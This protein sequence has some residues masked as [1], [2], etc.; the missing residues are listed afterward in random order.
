[1]HAVH[2]V[3]AGPGGAAVLDDAQLR[4]RSPHVER[5]QV[6]DAHQAPEIGGRFDPRRRS[7]LDDLHR[8]PF[9][10][11]DGGRA[12]VRKH[13][14]Q[15]VP[16]AALREPVREP[17]EITF[18]H[19]LDVG[20]EHGGRSAFVLLG[21]RVHLVRHRDG[22]ARQLL[23]ED[24]RRA[25]L[26]DAVAIG[27]QERDRDRADALVAEDG[28]G[29]ADGRLVQGNEH[30]TVREHPFRDAEPQPAGHHR[31]GQ[32]DEHVV[33]VVADLPG[34]LED[35]AEAFGREQ[36]GLRALALEDDVGDEGGRVDH[37]GGPRQQVRDRAGEIGDAAHHR[38]LG[39]VRGG[40]GLLDPDGAVGIVDHGEVGEG[41]ADVDAEAES[42][43]RIRHGHL[44]SCR[45]RSMVQNPPCDPAAVSRV[46]HRGS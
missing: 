31:L 27:M 5:Q 42:G 9:R 1:M 21:L 39:G 12:A 36:S 14:E 46:E 8:H 45:W 30:R 41:A 3:G 25:P 22:Y 32:A 43:S 6:V 20:I 37:L 38:L 10:R 11:L 19:R 23:A 35:V 2:L 26:V 40:Q 18:R 4:G 7:R 24:L 44:F 17:L 28:R 33:D 34:Q 16:V 13:D 29:P 15:P